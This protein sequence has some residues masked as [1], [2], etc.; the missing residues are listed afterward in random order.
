MPEDIFLRA[1]VT[2]A[3]QI[4]VLTIIV[5]LLVRIFAA[6][7]PQVAHWLWLIV[8]VKCVTPPLW[9]H[10][11]GL[12]SQ[13]QSVITDSDVQPIEPVATAAE[14]EITA[15][16]SPDLFADEVDVYPVDS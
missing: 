16:F 6:R 8:V 14:A 9:G 11:L 15:E 7:R 1:I 2:Q 4:A 10:S 5:A 3:W 13:I 12:F